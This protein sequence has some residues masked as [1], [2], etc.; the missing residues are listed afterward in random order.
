[1]TA[2]TAQLSTSRKNGEKAI[3]NSCSCMNGSYLSW[4]LHT[5]PQLVSHKEDFVF[6]AEPF[7]SFQTYIVDLHTKAIWKDK[8]T[9]HVAREKSI[10]ISEQCC[11]EQRYREGEGEE[12]TPWRR[13]QDKTKRL[14]KPYCRL[15]PGASNT[16]VQ[17]Q[18]KKVWY[19]YFTTL[20]KSAN[21]WLPWSPPW[22]L[23]LPPPKPH[24]MSALLKTY[25]SIK[26]RPA[27]SCWRIRYHPK[28][29]L[30]ILLALPEKP[31]ALAQGEH[32]GFVSKFRS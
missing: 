10:F 30:T 17:G 12:W 25:S 11:W 18:M 26:K 8:I 19:F 27:A 21:R 5:L 28:L 9:S 16:F 13:I 24:S 4:T 32:Q 31:K 7:N 6:L 14:I 29:V 2:Y 15:D 20:L 23:I 22:Q 3:L 1:M